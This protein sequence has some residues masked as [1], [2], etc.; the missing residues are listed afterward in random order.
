M[1]EQLD[2]KV[3]E[4]ITK[5]IKSF[6]DDIKG[7]KESMHSEI[8]DVRK[9]AEEAK[10]LPED[11]VLKDQLDKFAESI[12]T[13]QDAMDKAV[14]AATEQADKIETILKRSPVGENSNKDETKQ[15]IDFNRTMGVLQ[16]AVTTMRPLNVEGV[17]VD[18]YGLYT[19]AFDRYL[20]IGDRALGQ[21]EMKALSVASDPDGGYL[22]PTAMSQRI[23]EKVFETSQIRD[24]ATVETIGTSELDVPADEDEAAAGWVGEQA[25]RAETA[26]PTRGMRKI[27]VHELHASPRAT[28]KLLDDAS[29]DQES[30][31]SRK[32][33]GKFARLENT[34]FV[35]GNGVNKPRGMLTYA[36]GTGASQIN[37]INS[38]SATLLTADGIKGLPMELKEPYQNNAW[39]LMKRSSLKAVLLFKDSNN[40][41]L[42]RPGLE[43]K[44]PSS[45]GGYS[46]RMADDM[47]AVGAGALSIIFG[48]IRQA[49]TIV[50]RIGVRVL[51]DPFTAKPFVVFYTT[52]RV[53]GDVVN[54]EAIVIQK[55]AA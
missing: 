32:V 48:D 1:T 25:T 40:Q 55:V 2:P 47:P 9:V 7:L 19:K 49:Y 21:D 43:Q 22:V 30:W 31:L 17:D 37:Q 13:K 3:V 41:Y 39:W 38:G 54:F 35:N 34:A 26:T 24:L 42:W 4:Q 52:K 8:A 50:D 45:L 20:S 10:G 5:E 6:G 29:Q 46:V 15:A 28:Q 23:V 27:I 33:G 36:A 11:I 14:K 18:E 16:G 44:G 53:G 51:R 12:T